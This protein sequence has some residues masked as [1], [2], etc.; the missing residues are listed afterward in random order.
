MSR[1]QLIRC[2][3]YGPLVTHEAIVKT[4]TEGP[5]RTGFFFVCVTI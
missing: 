5:F 2:V 3:I 1:S 4:F